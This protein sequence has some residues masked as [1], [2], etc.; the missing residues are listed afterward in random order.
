SRLNRLAQYEAENGGLGIDDLIQQVFKRT[1]KA[2]RLEGIEELILEQNEQL[3][4]T[5]LLSVSQNDAASFATKAAI[6]KAIDDLQQFAQQQ[7]RL[8]R[9]NKGHYLLALERIKFLEKSKPSQHIDI[10]PG[11]PIGNASSGCENEW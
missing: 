4:L 9:T 7:V 8:N 3:V 1:W 10:P 11:S 5:Y 6:M 2:V